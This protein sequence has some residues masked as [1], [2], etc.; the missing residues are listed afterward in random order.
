M[1]GKYE[2]IEQ[3]KAILLTL[4]SLVASISIALFIVINISPLFVTVPNHLLGLSHQAILS[5]YSRIITYLQFPGNHLLELK[6]IPITGSAVNHFKDVKRLVLLNELLIFITGPSLVYL[7]KI[8]KRQ[9]QLWR[10]ILRFRMLFIL[11]IFGGF[12]GLTNFNSYFIKFHYLVF[13]NMDWVFNPTTNPVIQLMPE[14]FFELL[15]GLWFIIVLVILLL[16]WGWIKL[17]LRIFFNKS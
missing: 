2:V 17:T 16:I 10:L 13:S 12:V 3:G 1:N 7:L 5:D 6:Y 15:F 11:L 4:L 9:N 8:Q 14:S